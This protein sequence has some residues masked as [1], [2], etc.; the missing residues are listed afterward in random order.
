MS[1][2]HG[3]NAYGF[4]GVNGGSV[5]TQGLQGQVPFAFFLEDLALLSG[6]S[7]PAS[8]AR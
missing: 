5:L 6:S 3:E 8:A 7:G 1:W 4:Y 2:L